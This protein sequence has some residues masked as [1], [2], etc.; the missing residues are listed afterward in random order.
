MNAKYKIIIL[1]LAA[2]SVAGQ[3]RAGE[4]DNRMEMARFVAISHGPGTIRP[5]YNGKLLIV[6]KEYTVVAQPR[7]GGHF[8]NW[9]DG[10]ETVVTNFPRLTFVM[11]TNAMF[12]AH[13]DKHDWPPRTR[14]R[15]PG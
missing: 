7:A 15:H 12:I 11:T 6:G 5:D 3:L 8:T 14:R 2:A 4:Q 13:F 10:Y 1:A 9:T